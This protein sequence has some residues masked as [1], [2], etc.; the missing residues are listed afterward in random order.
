M[1]VSVE[2]CL[3]VCVWECPARMS[4]DQRN[5]GNLK[6]SVFLLPDSSEEQRTDIVTFIVNP[7]LV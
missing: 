3:S 4:G 2:I 7:L 5:S 1:C 6:T